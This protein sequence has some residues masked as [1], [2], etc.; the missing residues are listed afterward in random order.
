MPGT[1]SVA[2]TSSSNPPDLVVVTSDTKTGAGNA[3]SAHALTSV[4]ANALL[5][6]T[7]GQ[8][9]AATLATVT[10]S[11]A[12]TWT[13]R[14]HV[15]DGSN[16]I[17]TAVFTAGGNIN[18]TTS[19]AGAALASSACYVVTGQEAILAGTYAQK[20]NTDPPGFGAPVSG[21]I[22]T[23][24][25]GSIVFGVIADRNGVGGTTTYLDS[26]T[27]T[28]TNQ[29]SGFSSYHFYK[30]ATTPAVHTLGLS[31]PSAGAGQGMSLYEVRKA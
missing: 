15:R 20:D 18:V 5:V 4:A 21:D 25:T 2:W 29:P 13:R 10:S 12:L 30:Q 3:L 26:P 16:E 11:P 27:V 17:H 19:W 14:V 28:L 1:A 22:T 24:R 7:T 31:A 8:D 6:V 9:A 23:T